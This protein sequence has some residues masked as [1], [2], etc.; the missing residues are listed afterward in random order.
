LII[1]LI[2]TMPISKPTTM[3]SV[4]GSRVFILVP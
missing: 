2:T 1:A 4:F 3:A